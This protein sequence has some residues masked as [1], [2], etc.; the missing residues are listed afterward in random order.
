MSNQ[1]IT[2]GIVL[3]RTDFREADRILTIIT[4]DQGK[5][6]IIAKGVRRLRSKLAGGIELLSVSNLSVIPGRGELGTLISS[7]LVEHYGNIVQD[8]NRTMI[9][10]DFLKRINR[11]TEDAAGEEYFLI[12][13]RTLKALND[14]TFSIELTELWFSMQL[15][16]VTGLTPNLRTDLSGQKLQLEQSYSFDFDQMAFQA[17]PSAKYSSNHIKLLRLARSSEQPLMLKN[18]MNATDCVVEA[19]KLANS[20]LAQQ[21]RI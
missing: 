15:L 5:L 10:Y 2:T 7:R 6:K 11:T 21:I 20:L 1:I 9:S 14:L 17:E 16:N 18:I 19:N 8:I 4:P 12:L 3:A 13:Q